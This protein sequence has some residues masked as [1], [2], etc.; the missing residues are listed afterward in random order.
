MKANEN[1]EE[2]CGTMVRR[3][4]VQAVSALEGR[5]PPTPTIPHNKMSRLMSHAVLSKPKRIDPDRL[6]VRSACI[7][8]GCAIVGGGTVI[9]RRAKKLESVLPNT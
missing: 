9:I 5:L 8:S 3:F 6:V 2:D 1:N 7:G 4:L